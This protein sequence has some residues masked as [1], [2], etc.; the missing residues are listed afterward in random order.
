M[1]PWVPPPSIYRLS[2]HW[3]PNSWHRDS[4]HWWQVGQARTPLSPLP[5]SFLGR[6]FTRGMSRGQTV[7][8]DYTQRKG[9]AKMPAPDK[10]S[11][12]PYLPVPWK[13]EGGGRAAELTA[14]GLGQQ[15]SGWTLPGQQEHLLC[16]GSG[17]WHWVTQ[18][19]RRHQ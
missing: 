6:R 8:S 14:A 4:R 11:R 19:H 17:S 1:L 16:W 3:G 18:A 9:S 12:P 13:G 15:S 7:W 5:L 10:S 2:V